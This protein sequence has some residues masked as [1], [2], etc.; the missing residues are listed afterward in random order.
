MHAPHETPTAVAAPEKILERK[1]AFCE[2]GVKGALHAAPQRLQHT[3]LQIFGALH[4]RR[5]VDQGGKILNWRCRDMSRL[6]GL[7][8]IIARAQ[9]N[10]KAHGEIAPPHERGRQIASCLA[11]AELQEAM[12]GIACEMLFEPIGDR[13]IEWKF[14][15]APIEAQNAMRR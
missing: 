5:L 2:F 7:L 3:G 8:R 12:T 10:H 15:V 11:G 13:L 4:R 6:F 9:H 14:I 1:P